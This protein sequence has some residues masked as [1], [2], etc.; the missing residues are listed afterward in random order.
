MEEAG[1]VPESWG[2]WWNKGCEMR[3][4]IRRQSAY[5][6]PEVMLMFEERNF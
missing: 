1:K 6:V 2:C 5:P 4:R 3:G